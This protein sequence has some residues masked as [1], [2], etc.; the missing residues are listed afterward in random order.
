MRYIKV[1]LAKKRGMPSAGPSISL[2]IQLE[3]GRQSLSL[4][5]MSLHPHSVALEAAKRADYK[6]IGK[7][8][9]LF[10]QNHIISIVLSSDKYTARA[11]R[12][13]A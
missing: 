7:P 1:N 13:Q 4:N 9:I 2:S 10:S 11:K 5:F 6:S 8:K 12:G 3:A